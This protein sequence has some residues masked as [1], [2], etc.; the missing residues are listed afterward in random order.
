MTDMI[1][2]CS[3]F[4]WA[5]M[6]I[7][8]SL[9]NEIL[10]RPAWFAPP[11]SDVQHNKTVNATFWPWAWFHYSSDKLQAIHFS[12]TPQV[13]HLSGK[14]K[15]SKSSRLFLPLSAAARASLSERNSL[16]NWRRQTVNSRRS[17]RARNE[18]TTGPKRLR[19]DHSQE[20]NGK[21]YHTLVCEGFFP[22]DFEGSVTT[23]WPSLHRI[24]S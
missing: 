7:I 23:S 20:V 9:P 18:G 4:H 6:F 16:L 24:N 14:I 12:E 8:N 22:L 1:R 5:W 13:I 3:N 17:E 19:E 15:S 11:P 21:R 2:V 10:S